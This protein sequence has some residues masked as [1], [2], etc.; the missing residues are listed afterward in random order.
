M[1]SSGIIKRSAWEETELCFSYRAPT[2]KELMTIKKKLKK[3]FEAAAKT[4]DC[5]CEYTFLEDAKN[6]Y[7]GM[8]ANKK[9]AEVFAR[10]A[11]AKGIIFQDGNPSIC[12]SA[13]STDMGNVSHVVP[14]I[15]PEYCI[16]ARAPHVNHTPGFPRNLG[17]IRKGPGPIPKIWVLLM[18]E[19]GFLG[20]DD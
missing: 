10:H 15:Q 2:L 4:T 14:A 8:I 12:E 6:S 3:C 19:K 1:E 5:I 16:G 18:A 9:L 7:R 11:E 13:V 20:I 17:W